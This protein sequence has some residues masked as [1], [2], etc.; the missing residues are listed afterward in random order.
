MEQVCIPDWQHKFHVI[1][2]ILSMIAVP[3]LWAASNEIDEPHALR[4]KALAVAII[5]IDG[6]LILRWMQLRYSA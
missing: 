2:E 5:I 3:M 4:L 6:G 1:T